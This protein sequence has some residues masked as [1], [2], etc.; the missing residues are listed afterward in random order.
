MAEHMG[1]MDKHLD[2]DLIFGLAEGGLDA[3]ARASAEAH[4]RNCA[5]C[6]RE[7]EAAAGYF[8]EI[9][10]LEPVKAPANFLAHVRARLPRPSPFRAFLDVFMKPLRVIPMQVALLTILGLTAISSYL[11]QRGGLNKDAAGVISESP[12]EPA[13]EL[14]A[15][16]DVGP[17]PAAPA[18]R[19]ESVAGNPAAASE[20]VYQSMKKAEPDLRATSA[21]SRSQ[22][23]GASRSRVE[24]GSSAKKSS[25]TLRHIPGQAQKGQAQSDQDEAMRESD[26]PIA[27]DRAAS[28]R[29]P[30]PASWQASPPAPS[31]EMEPGPARTEQPRAAK[32]AAKNDAVKEKKA[33]AK[34]GP[35]DKIGDKSKDME[36]VPDSQVP[37]NAGALGSAEPP[38][39]TVSLAPGKRIGDAVSGLKAMGID[40]L[41]A[42]SARTGGEPGGGGIDYI[43]QAP[44]SMRT[45]IAP[46]LERYGKVEVAGLPAAAGGASL[47]IRIRFL[48]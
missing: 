20:R 2:E 16:A 46:Y 31:P 4:L 37:G 18:E 23:N 11:Y 3:A 47:R 30:A 41:S 29:A 13:A 40:S 32:E 39:F 12:A 24:A 5:A 7:L 17:A 27:P 8:K 36:E 48:P 14:P 42:R 15:D 19:P 34:F 44:A 10:G 21:L 38:A 26:S 22:A 33:E 35:V 25:Q 9:A 43:F 45:E 28:L 1:D 6:R